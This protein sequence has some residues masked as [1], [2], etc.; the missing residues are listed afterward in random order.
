MKKYWGQFPNFFTPAFIL[1]YTI[2]AITVSV[3]RYYQF[4][5]FYF[6]LG[7]FD[8]AI[9][10][11]S[12]FLP[13]LV[14]HIDYGDKLIHIFANH[15]N[16]S[17]FL[18]SPLFWLANKTEILLIA[19]SICVGLAAF[20]AF[21]IA[22][23][24]VNN[25]FVVF[26]LV[27]AFLGY[28]GLQNALISDFHDAT[29]A[30]LPIMIIFWAYLE[31]K[32][33]VFFTALV[34]VLGFKESFA[35]FGVALSLFIIIQDRS[36]W[37]ISVS[38]F[39]I[40]II[41]G[42]LAIFKI[43]PSFS[44]GSYLFAPKVIPNN[45]FDYLNLFFYPVIKI[46]TMALSYLTFSLLPLINIATL[47]LVFENF[48]ERFI[49]SADK[50]RDLGMHYNAPLSPILFMGSFL[51]YIWLQK[52]K[53]K[54]IILYLLAG[55]TIVSVIVLHRFILRGP[56]GL[57][58]NPVFYQQTGNISYA[59]DFISLTPKEGIIMTQNDLATRFA[60]SDVRLLRKNYKNIDPD[61]VL[62]NLTPG[63]NI[64]SYFPLSEKEVIQLKDDLSKDSNYSSN[65]LYDEVYLFQKIN[66]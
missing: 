11:V 24:R 48:F 16:P 36:L 29:V 9:W 32:W 60:H 43:I 12:R 27:F 2:A 38:T 50:G 35:G 23:K 26:S 17:I 4:Q 64:N 5:N 55:S 58:Y 46:R 47:P 3:G 15:F 19:Q 39:V 61:T 59:N 54:E 7:I 22:N 6:D 30:V 14:D 45:L 51:V 28:V 33:S 25:K 49:L 40:S 62:I 57:F 44:G 42:Y 20:V 63:Q 8:S 53:V 13:P 10:K 41:W 34:V 21:R 66:E 1:V 18:F 65:K 52:I 56:L 31:K 37:K